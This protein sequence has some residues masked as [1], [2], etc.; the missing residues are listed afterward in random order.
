MAAAL[1]YIPAFNAQGNPIPLDPAKWAAFLDV[2]ARPYASRNIRPYI[3][4]VVH[5]GNE[6][7]YY[8]MTSA[9]KRDFLRANPGFFCQKINLNQ[10]V[11][12]SAAALHQ[13][14][15]DY[16]DQNRVLTALV[17]MAI[18]SEAKDKS[19]CQAAARKILHN[20]RNLFNT[21]KQALPN[22]SSQNARVVAKHYRPNIR[23]A[24]PTTLGQ[25][26]IFITNL[27][28]SPNFW[29]GVKFLA[30]AAAVTLVVVTG[31]LEM[32]A[33]IIASVIIQ[34]AVA[35]SLNNC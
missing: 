4:S 7:D 33:L 21:H 14:A 31:R 6:Q 24:A 20:F 32:I 26:N 34:Q 35:K 12:V 13:S 30:L 11:E 29:K 10:I 18:M 5:Q 22:T 2:A 17:N 1:N 9:Q 15:F 19:G 16:T 28:K 27:I 8:A 23:P 25:I 3:Y